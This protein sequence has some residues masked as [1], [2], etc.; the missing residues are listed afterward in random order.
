MILSADSCNTWYLSAPRGS[1]VARAEAEMK[2]ERFSFLGFFGVETVGACAFV[3]NCEANN[4]VTAPRDG[5]VCALN[6][7]FHK[8]AHAIL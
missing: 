2:R 1:H 5:S 8:N 4:A 3:F 6:F 7:L